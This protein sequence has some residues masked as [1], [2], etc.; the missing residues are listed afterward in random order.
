[1]SHLEIGNVDCV[2]TH[3]E[4]AVPS[5]IDRDRFRTSAVTTI[6]NATP[7]ICTLG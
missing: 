4:K 6:P 7:D 2:S 3:S 1:M 5:V